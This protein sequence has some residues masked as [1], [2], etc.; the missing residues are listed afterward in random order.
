MSSVGDQLR[1]GLALL[2]R[3]LRVAVSYRTR[4]LTQ[5]LAV[6]FSLTLFHFIAQLVRVSTFPT[7]EAYFSFAVVGLIS[8]QVLNST[9]VTPPGALRQELVAGTF[10]RLLVSPFG[11]VSSLVA[12]LVFPLL[13][14]LTTAVAMLAFAGLAFGVELDWS[15]VPLVVPVGLLGALSFAPF[16]VLFLALMMLS[17]QAISGA[18][19]L[20]AGIS[21]IAGLYFPISL[22]PGWIR[23]ASDVQ[24]FTPAVDLLRHVMVGTPLHEAL[25]LELTKL[26][27][28][29]TALLPLSVLLLAATIRHSRGR[30]TVLEY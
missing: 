16:G 28:F 24:P 18:T 15:T 21:L 23:W 27:G 8:L 7:P 22:L 25:A 6:F 9:L 2:R 17:R 30:G 26:V 20:V 1:A 10:E 19:F 3:D 29:T 4:F 14:A 5:L 12:G 13:A 11:A